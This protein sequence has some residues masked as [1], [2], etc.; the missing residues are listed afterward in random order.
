MLGLAEIV[1]QSILYSNLFNKLLS[2]LID[3]FS[4]SSRQF[5]L[6]IY[7]SINSSDQKWPLFELKLN[8][9]CYKSILVTADDHLRMKRVME[10]DGKTYREVEAIMKKQMDNTTFLFINFILLVFNGI[11]D[12][13]FFKILY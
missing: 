5:Q 13:L 6:S 7:L 2:H 8:E 1:S 12:D 10:R 11:I 3:L 9:S 4:D